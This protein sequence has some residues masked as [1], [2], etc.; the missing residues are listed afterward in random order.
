MSDGVVAAVRRALLPFVAVALVVG[1]VAS[2]LGAHGVAVAV[3]SMASGVVAVDLVVVTIARLREGRVAV[4]VVA[5]VALL[6]SMVMGEAL[7]GVILAL[8]VASGD[9]LEQYAHRRAE[10]SLAELLSLAPKTAHR[11]VDGSFETVPVD[12]VAP[13]EVLLVKPGE[14]VPADGTV[15]ESAVLDESVL[16]GEAQSVQREVGEWARSGSLNAGGAFR[17]RASVSADESSY[18]GIV[19]L[20]RSAGVGRAPFV[21]LAD[22]YA[23]MF[24]PAVF[25]VAAGTWMVTGEST[26]V[27]AV[28]VVATPCPLVLAAPV[29]VVSGIACA[30]RNGAVVKDGAALE[31]MG[32]TRTVLL[33]KTGTLTAGR[34]HVVAV[35]TAPGHE[36]ADVLALAAS[37]EQASPHVLAA[38]LVREARDRG[39]TMVE[40]AGV[41]EQPG[42]GV[43]GAVAGRQVWVGVLTSVDTEDRAPW[44][45]AAERRARREG[46]STTVVVVD[47]EPV[48]LILFT[49]ELRTDT[50]AALRTLRRAGVE[51]VVM[52]TGDRLEVAEPIGMSLGIDQVFADRTPAE[53]LEV[54][55]AESSSRSGIT[56][57][58]GD[59]VNDAPALAAADLGVAMGARGAT[60]SSEAADVVLIVDRLDRLA[61]GVV[62]AKRARAIARQSVLLGMGLSLLGMGAAAVGL[63]APVGAA[64]SQEVIDVLAIGM[65]LRALRQPRS[66]R[67]T[68]S[69]PDS[70]SRQLA[71]GHGPL[72]LVLEELRSVALAMDSADEA[73]ALTSLREVAARIS[74][75]VVPHEREDESQVYPGVAERLGG[76]DPLAPMSRTHQEIFH[77]AS[78]LDRL[79]D[80]ASVDGFGDEDRSE[81]R[82]ILYALDAILRLH[83]S[84]EEELLAS[85]TLDGPREA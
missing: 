60:A 25:L 55:R 22:R 24:V 46:C 74:E 72:R 11:L 2:F 16:T 18:A 7:A 12:D 73:T 44:L 70:W 53:K 69:V 27:L 19:R 38:M 15:L 39:L 20:V 61:A 30:A 49:D 4:D 32:Q 13:G 81:A 26:R 62:I 23:V 77:L 31:A 8:M 14:V 45:L 54:V 1:A 83:F 71:G 65:A 66:L 47:D 10:R 37:L 34:A 78:L 84:Q 35:V 5:L 28:L 67:H 51:R 63:L 29:A 64:V 58:V 6:A 57:M 3:W 59:G 41:I 82:R 68:G 43:S 50:S 79:V 9:A 80:D 42:S 48:G 85:I 40:P 75:E 76:N 17:M 56:V 33:D 21:R 52:V 36:A